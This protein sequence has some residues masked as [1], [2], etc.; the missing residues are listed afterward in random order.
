MNA[1]YCP[2]D[3][4]Q[5]IDPRGS[6]G[7]ALTMIVKLPSSRSHQPVPRQATVS[8]RRTI[9]PEDVVLARQMLDREH[10]VLGGIEPT[11]ELILTTWPGEEVL[12]KT[13][14]SL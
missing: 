13:K 5:I 3:F 8:T 1:P 11:A 6:A 7:L 10:N 12:E 2:V 9:Q 14:V 4:P